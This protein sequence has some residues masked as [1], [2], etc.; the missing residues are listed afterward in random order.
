MP[1]ATVPA[2]APLLLTPGPLST[3][4]GVRE[5]MLHDWGSWDSDFKQLTVDMRAAVVGIAGSAE[6]HTCVPVQGSGTFAVEAAVGTLLPR[7]GKLLVL[8]NGWYGTRMAQLTR[9]MGRACDTYEVEETEPHDPKELARR[10]A[11][12]PAI[13]HVGAIPV[14]TSTGILNPVDDLA[15]T[16]AQAGR[17]LIV[18]GMSSFG[19]V[20]NGLDT[21]PAQA[22]IAS[23]NKCLQGPPGMGFMVASTAD[24]EAAADRSPS[25][26]L[27]LA[28]QWRHMERT[29]QWRFTPPT[30]V[31]AGFCQAL[32]E[33]R[34][35]GGQEARLA[36]YRENC[37]ILCEGMDELGFRRLLPDDRQA[38]VIVTFHTPS[39]G[40]YSFS[41]FYTALKRRG[42]IIYPGKTTRRDTFRIGCIGHLFADDMHRL[43]AAV[44]ESVDEL[45]VRTRTP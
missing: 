33:Y 29:G 3:S 27:D 26:S 41:A 7:D 19:I 31:V 45:G 11:T 40:C 4:P 2:P 18:D 16:V 9:Q 43:L 28:D 36:R 10:L 17:R 24:L 37:R 21:L 42:F 6:R 38:P 15:A 39:D 14:E 34:A 44:A 12:D 22:V 25:L 30:H 8:V 5:A 1:A 35:E 32:R 23:S 20:P 13:T